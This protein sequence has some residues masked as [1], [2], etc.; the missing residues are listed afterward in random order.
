MTAEIKITHKGER[1]RDN[2]QEYY[3]VRWDAVGRRTGKPYRAASHIF[4][5]RANAE[6]FAMD[7][8]NPEIEINYCAFFM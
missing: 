1:N 7:K 3:V 4:T 5:N 6:R 2:Q 8:P